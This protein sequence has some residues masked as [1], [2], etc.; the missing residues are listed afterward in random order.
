MA[1]SETEE[2][3]AGRILDAVQDLVS[4]YSAFRF[5]PNSKQLIL[6]KLQDFEFGMI[7]LETFPVRTLKMLVPEWLFGAIENTVTFENK[8]RKI[9]KEWH[10]QKTATLAAMTPFA[11]VRFSDD[12]H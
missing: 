8:I 1:F 6:G 7:S 11:P 3:V 10:M 4:Q 5:E 2:V 9:V 12:L